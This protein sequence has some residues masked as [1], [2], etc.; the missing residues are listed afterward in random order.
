MNPAVVLADDLLGN[1]ADPFEIRSDSR[2][3]YLSK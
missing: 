1:C 2:D 3:G